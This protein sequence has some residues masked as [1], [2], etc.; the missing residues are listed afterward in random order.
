MLHRIREAWMPHNGGGT[1]SVE[2]GNVHGWQAQEHEHAKRATLSGRGTVGKT[3]IVGLKDRDTNQVT[4]EKT[5]KPTLQFVTDPDAT[6]TP[7]MRWST[8]P[9]PSST[10][11]FA[12]ALRSTS[13]NKPT[14][15]ESSPS[16]RC[17]SGSYRN[18]PQD[19]S[20]ILTATRGSTRP[21]H[22]RPNARSRPP[23]RRTLPYKKLTAC[24]GLSSGARS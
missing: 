15:T 12:T 9:Y 16:G 24:N 10:R 19:V 23:T 6:S 17:S 22:S 18:L 5:D 3:A 20:Q 11:R 1:L 8:R 7:M 21:R 14:P 2:V 13:M 4:V